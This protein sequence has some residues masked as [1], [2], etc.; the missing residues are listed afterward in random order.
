LKIDFSKKVYKKSELEKE[1]AERINR[2]ELRKIDDNIN[3]ETE[4]D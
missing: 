4:E 3:F 2:V 1:L